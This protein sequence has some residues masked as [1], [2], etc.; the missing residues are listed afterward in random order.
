MSTVRKIAKNIVSLASAELITKFLMFILIVLI[1]RYLGDVNYGKYAFAMVFTSFFLILSDLGLSTLTIREV[2]REKEFA[3]KYFGNLSL[4]KLI[5]SV[6]S[7]LLLVVII[8]LMN[9]PPDTTL[10]VYIAGMYVVVSSFNQFFISFFRA[11]ER[12]EYETLVRVFEKIIAFTLVV[13][14]I[15]LGYGLIEI[16]LAFLFSG[17]FSFLISCLIVLKKFTKPEFE[18]DISFL[19]HA[20][21]EALPFGLTAVFVVIYFKIDTVMLSVMKGD[22]VVGWYNAAYQIIFGLMILPAA[23][24]N[25]IFPIMSRYYKQSKDSLKIVYETA[26]RYLLILAIPI[27]VV[28]FIFADEIISLLYKQ[29]YT[30][31]VQALQVLIFVI[32]VIFLTYLFGNTLQA[33]N[34][35]QVV[36]YVAMSNAIL[37][38]AL[39]WML[40]P[41][42]SYVGASIATLLTEILGLMLMF[43]YISKHFFRISIKN[44]IIKPICGGMI[45]FVT[46]YY[47]KQYSS[48][49]LSISVSMSM[50][51]LTLFL[52]G[53]LSKYDIIL[54]KKIFKGGE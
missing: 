34:K 16:M 18:V 36:N 24:V 53:I 49:A 7:F 47:L 15:Y 38:V 39:N 9:Y 2:A 20:I 19:K 29:Q 45:F 23:F 50:Y 35:Q 41:K 8:N 42:Y 14:L 28:G 4:V 27:T 30:Q 22:A 33:L 26:L 12:M 43:G 54:F 6:V 44:D 21:K 31:S 5:L 13:S 52:L 37:N 51:L 40:I 46:L 32:P 3:G 48:P 11:F 10:A 17:I 1:A 25:A